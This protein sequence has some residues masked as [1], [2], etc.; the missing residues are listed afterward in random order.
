ME[1]T[2]HVWQL[3]SFHCQRLSHYSPEPLPQF[4]D[5]TYAEFKQKYLTLNIAK[6][7]KGLARAAAW[8]PSAHTPRASKKAAAR[9]GLLGT[10]PTAWDWAASGGVTSIKDQ[11]QCGSC[12]AFAVAAAI[13]SQ[14]WGAPRTWPALV[15][16]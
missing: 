10:V 14:V 8:K 5:L 1:G 7:A 9:R 15:L 2:H 16:A 6:K 4:S 12:Y 11:G 13:E 3:L